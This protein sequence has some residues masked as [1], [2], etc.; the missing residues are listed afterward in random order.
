MI[1]YSARH[2]LLISF[3]WLPIPQHCNICIYKLAYRVGSQIASW[4]VERSRNSD[5]EDTAFWGPRGGYLHFFKVCGSIST[6]RGVFLVF[7]VVFWISTCDNFWLVLG[8]VASQDKKKAPVHVLLEEAL[9]ALLLLG[10]A[11]P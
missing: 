6:S 9:F 10:P 5:V 7:A 3:F 2:Q 11:C 8:C 1:S 4:A